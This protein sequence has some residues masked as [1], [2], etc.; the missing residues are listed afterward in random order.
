MFYNVRVEHYVSDD[1]GGQKKQKSLYVVEASSAF[2]AASN[3]TE[4]LGPELTDMDIEMVA[5][6]HNTPEYLEQ[7]NYH[8]DA[9]MFKCKIGYESSNTKG[10]TIKVFEYLLVRANSSKF[11]I[12][13]VKTKFTTIM[14]YDIPSVAETNIKDVIT[15]A[16]LK[17]AKDTKNQ[18]NHE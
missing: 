11:A 13:T 6:A 5:K 8:D 15:V 10:K 16:Q 14:E 7:D 9:P 1:K 18:E 17:S 2:E 4:A 3:A 12:D